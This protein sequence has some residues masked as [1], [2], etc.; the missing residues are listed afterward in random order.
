QHHRQGVS[1]HRHRHRRARDRLYRADL[2]LWGACHLRSRIRHP[3]VTVD[4][5]PSAGRGW[6]ILILAFIAQMFAIGTASYG[7]GLLVKPIAAE[8]GLSRANAN[9][10][11]VILLVGMAAASPLIGRALDRYP[12]RY[13]LQIGAAMLGGGCILIAF[14]NSLW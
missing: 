12:P 11:L 10:G 8:F 13:V 7:F 4:L 9:M 5:P 6:R 3:V 14:A 1:R 2:R